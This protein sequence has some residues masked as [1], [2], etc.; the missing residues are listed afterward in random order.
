LLL[1]RDPRLVLWRKPYFNIPY[2]QFRSLLVRL[3]HL[4]LRFLACAG[5]E[6][7]CN[8][9]NI[10]VALR[11]LWPHFPAALQGERES[12]FLQ[13]W[14]LAWRQEGRAP[15]TAEPSPQS[16]A[17]SRP[18]LG[19][20]AIATA[21][22]FRPTASACRGGTARVLGGTASRHQFG[23]RIPADWEASQ[24]ALLRVMLEGPLYWLGFAELS[25]TDGQSLAAGDGQLATFRLHGLAN[26]IWDRPTARFDQEGKPPGEAVTID[27]SAGTISMQPGA[28]APQAHTFLGRVARLEEASPERFLYH[29]HPRAALATFESGTS[30]SDLLAEWERVMPKAIPSALQETLSQWWTRYGQVRL[31]DGFGLLEVR[32]EVTLRELEAGT[33][34]SQHIVARL[35][36]R[37]VLVPDEAVNGLLREFAAKDYT[38][39]EVD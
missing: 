24:G 37:T 19:E 26:W 36:P 7:W 34:L 20:V 22:S 10:E 11:K 28:V 9:T 3:R 30:L 5:E 4:L 8:L 2:D 14:G 13:A 21:S 38:P 6:G 25:Y 33:S 15:E 27:E 16:E 32:D 31:Y 17:E 29:L 23:E 35:S 1:R 39:K 12:W 18:L